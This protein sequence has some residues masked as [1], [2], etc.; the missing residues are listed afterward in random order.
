MTIDGFPIRNPKLHHG[1]FPMS[2]VPVVHPQPVIASSKSGPSHKKCATCDRRSS[3][4]KSGNNIHG[5]QLINEGPM[6]IEN[7]ET[8][9][10]KPE[11]ETQK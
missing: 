1:N 4:C 5:L 10:D 3:T 8:H 9:R 2:M 7:I 6:R 11:V